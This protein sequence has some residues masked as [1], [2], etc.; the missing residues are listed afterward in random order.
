MLIFAALVIAFLLRWIV[1]ETFRDPYVF[2]DFNSYYFAAVVTKQG[3]NPY[4]MQALI[5]QAGTV[6]QT[7][8]E[9]VAPFRQTIGHVVPFLPLTSVSYRIANVTWQMIVALFTLFAV[10]LLMASA[11]NT[12]WKNT[13]ALL[14]GSFALLFGPLMYSMQLYQLNAVLLAALLLGLWFLRKNVLLGSLLIGLAASSKFFLAAP[15]FI[16]LLQKRWKPAIASMI[17]ATLFVILPFFFVPG[18][19]QSYT[20]SAVPELFSGD[21]HD[22]PINPQAGAGS[23]AWFRNVSLRGTAERLFQDQPVIS[24]LIV[25]PA[26]I[27]IAKALGTLLLLASV[28]LLF[29]ARFWLRENA[30]DRIYLGTGLLLLSYFLAAPFTWYHHL[31]FLLVLVPWFLQEGD[32][33]GFRR[34]PA[35]LAVLGVTLVSVMN[36]RELTVPPLIQHA[37]FL[38][39]ILGLIL[40]CLSVLLR[41]PRRL[42]NISGVRTS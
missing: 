17:F 9:T 16:L 15:V 33:V 24:P 27:G 14:A 40:L 31:T 10:W 42:F 38:M 18:S 6:R 37:V 22:N 34:V 25:W 21:L 2:R 12:G 41:L 30:D 8:A 19:W 36:F 28:F 29:R 13:K 23:P 35:L 7:L 3:G 20:Q 11:P 1:Q 39:P 32:R 5:A 26:A 4:D